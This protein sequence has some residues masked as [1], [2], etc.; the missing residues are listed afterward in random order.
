MSNAI[1]ITKGFPPGRERAVLLELLAVT[2]ALKKQGIDAVVCGGLH[3]F[4]VGRDEF[5]HRTTVVDGDGERNNRDE[6]RRSSEAPCGGRESE[7]R[8]RSFDGAK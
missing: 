3:L 8:V 7:I 2:Q 6:D 4:L 5:L 1:E